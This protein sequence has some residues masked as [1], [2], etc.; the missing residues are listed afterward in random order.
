MVK[1]KTETSN[2]FLRTSR[3]KSMDYN[4]EKKMITI[5]SGLRIF[6]ANT[7]PPA[8]RILMIGVAI[9][10]FGFLVEAI[11]ADTPAYESCINNT[12]HEAQCKDCCDCLDNPGERKDC[13]DACAIEDFTD[14]SNYIEVD[15]PSVLGPDGDYS[16][17]V[18]TGSEQACKTYCDESDLLACGDRRYCRDACNAAYGGTNPGPGSGN[19]SIDQAISDEAQMKTI[20]FDG[21]AFLTGDLCSDTFFPPGKVS[22]FFGFQYM[23]DIMPNGFGHNTEFAGRVSDSVLSI[24]TDAQVHALVSLANTQAEQVDAYGYK[25][26]VLMKAFRRL[27]END[28]PDGTSGLDENAVKEF[29]ADLYAIDS[30]I[31]Y[32]RANVIGSI[33]AALTE[34]QKT[35]LADLLIAFNT[36]FKNAGQGGTIGNE[37]WPASSPMDLSGLTVADGRVLVSTYATQLFSWYL[38]S[39]EGDTYFCP[40]RH[41]TYF[42]SFFMKDIPPITAKEPVTIDEGVTAEM[43]QAFLDVLDDTQKALV[44]GVVDIQRTDLYSIVSKRQEIAEKL[45]LFMNGSSVDNTE[46]LAL[47]RQYGEYEGAMMYHYATRFAAVGATLTHD[48]AD[49]V[50]GF[51]L[52]YYERFPDYQANPNAYDCSGAWLYA[53]KIDM[54]EIMNTDFLFG[55]GVLPDIKANGSDG[56]VTLS[57]EDMLTIAVSLDPGAGG[58]INAEWW[59]AAYCDNL[60]WWSYAYPQGWVEGITP[61]LQEPLCTLSSTVVLEAVLP[62]GNYTFYFA[63]DDNAD[64]N[65]D[66]QWLDD[67]QVEITLP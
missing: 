47:V 45:R 5:I 41:G 63:L 8:W 16:V 50:M 59:V 26:F 62:A 31:S 44:T 17:A 24:L 64:G 21:L 42:G 23:R 18:E 32:A 12:I 56:P 4:K 65:P 57:S 53:S 61:C 11:A 22:D 25:R 48:Q 33:V 54:P 37:D 36:L 35:Q 49:T 43:G 9:G 58:G 67:V 2:H 46:V 52:G 34:T 66:I 15:A 14:N 55:I 13:R 6:S 51:R 3:Q 19:I 29:T 40:E 10:L 20:A 38:G 27:L 28:L 60:G 7:I 30:E 1:I 39:V